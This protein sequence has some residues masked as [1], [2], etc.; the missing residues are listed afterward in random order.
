MTT[1]RITHASPAPTYVFTADRKWE[2]DSYL[3]DEAK[4]NGCP[5]MAAQLIGEKANKL[6]VTHL[7]FQIR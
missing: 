2:D 6:K 3:T 5:D 4:E 7:H 1:A